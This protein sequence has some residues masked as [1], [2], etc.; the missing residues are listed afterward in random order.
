MKSEEEWLTSI[1][2]NAI[3]KHLRTPDGKANVTQEVVNK[4]LT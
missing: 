3:R 1:I 2:D 4:I